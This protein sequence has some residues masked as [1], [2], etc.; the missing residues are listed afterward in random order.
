[1]VIGIDAGYGM[2][3][4][5]HVVF[6]SGVAHLNTAPP[7]LER[8]LQINGQYYQVGN[9][10]DGIAK[11]KTRDEDY[12][13]LTLAACAMEMSRLNIYSATITLAVGTP[14]MRYGEEKDKLISYLSQNESVDFVFEGKNYHITFDDKV[15]VYPQGYAAI[16]NRI[17][18]IKG[19]FFLVDIGTGTTEI[20]PVSSNCSIN[21]GKTFTLQNGINDCIKSIK[22]VI[23]DKFGGGL[24]L[25]EYIDIMRGIYDNKKV[26]EICEPIMID[27]VSTMLKLLNE[28]GVNYQLTPTYLVGG[29]AGIVKRYID[30]LGIDNNIRFIEDVK[31]NAIGY[32]MLAKAEINNRKEA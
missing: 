26:M 31:A 11:D 10:K 7:V 12:Y 22:A 28:N 21:L 20:L 19:S 27:F 1:M 4:T 6:P 15:F 32:E 17:G 23:S 16:V 2:T 24:M 3:K 13:L 8:V 14:L 18:E 25:E 29:G 5:K 9:V 30:R